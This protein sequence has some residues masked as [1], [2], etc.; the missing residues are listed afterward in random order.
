MAITPS[1]SCV[2][3][4]SCS[5]TGMPCHNS[6]SSAQATKEQNL[7]IVC[8]IQ[9]CDEPPTQLIDGLVLLIVELVR[10]RASVER[11]ISE[12]D[13]EDRGRVVQEVA[14]TRVEAVPGRAAY[15]VSFV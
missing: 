9:R 10:R 7:V 2:L 5:A 13:G 15:V 12:S 4:I 11:L 3:P 1:S 14:E 8:V 6:G